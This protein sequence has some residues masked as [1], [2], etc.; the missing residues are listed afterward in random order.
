MHTA[1]M[2][3]LANWISFVI[4]LQ[5][6]ESYQGISGDKGMKR[7]YGERGKHEC[8]A[9]I[10]SS[11]SSFVLISDPQ[12]Y[13][14]LPDLKLAGGPNS[15][16]LVL[17]SESKAS[18][19]ESLYFVQLPFHRLSTVFKFRNKLNLT[20]YPRLILTQLRPGCPYWFFTTSICSDNQVLISFP[21]SL[22]PV[23]PNTGPYLNTLCLLLPFCLCTSWR[24]LC[25]ISTWKILYSFFKSQINDGLFWKAFS[26]FYRQNK[27]L[28]ASA[29]SGLWAYL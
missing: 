20:F 13:L 10:Y 29:P 2:L 17:L 3:G 27:S 21:S 23:L 25:L 24:H 6:M 9:Q 15:L 5:V 18:H 28:L 7:G 11:M 8:H 16:D 4:S 19:S 22:P 12:Y 1:T 26:N 14:F